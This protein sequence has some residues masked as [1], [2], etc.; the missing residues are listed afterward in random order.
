[1]EVVGLIALLLAR[2]IQR[3]LEDAAGLL[4]T[5]PL[6]NPLGFSGQRSPLFV[7]KKNNSIQLIFPGEY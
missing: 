6:D 4:A 2:N 1:V 3:E 7:F 5:S